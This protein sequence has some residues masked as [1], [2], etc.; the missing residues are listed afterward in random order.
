[1]RGVIMDGDDIVSLKICDRIMQLAQ[2]V[3]DAICKSEPCS[4]NSICRPS[5]LDTFPS[6]KVLLPYLSSPSFPPNPSSNPHRSPRP[7]Y[8]SSSELPML[9]AGAVLNGSR[10]G[11]SRYNNSNGWK[12]VDINIEVCLSLTGHVS[13]GVLV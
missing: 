2:L 8:P 13:Y 1:K 10:V 11:V 5:P 12:G 6:G 7:I 3:K 9:Y 4:F